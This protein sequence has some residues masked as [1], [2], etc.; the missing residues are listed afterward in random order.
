MRKYITDYSSKAFYLCIFIVYF[1]CF[2]PFTIKNLD[3]FFLLRFGSIRNYS[4]QNITIYFLY[5]LILTLL[6]IISS[7]KL[8]N[9][10]LYLSAIINKFFYWITSSI[11]VMSFSFIAF[12]SKLS[13]FIQ[14]G[15]YSRHS[16]IFRIQST[17]FLG[18]AHTFSFYFLYNYLIFNTIYYFSQIDFFVP[19]LHSL[20]LLILQLAHWSY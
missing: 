18:I 6:A 13:L 1:I 17:G 7:F 14:Y 12:L 8:K 19:F 16:D 15:L 20:F 9:V 4:P 3:I 5:V 10:F 2:I 11:V